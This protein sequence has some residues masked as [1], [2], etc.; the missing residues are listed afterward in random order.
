MYLS[1]F[2]GLFSGL[3]LLDINYG[4]NDGA[5]LKTHKQTRL[6]TDG[7]F[8]H[9]VARK[10]PSNRARVVRKGPGVYRKFEIVVPEQPALTRFWIFKV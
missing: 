10:I 9:P 8:R 3:A 5:V 7:A 2:T 1:P 4:R 6:V